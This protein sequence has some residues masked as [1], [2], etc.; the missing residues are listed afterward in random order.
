[1][2]RTAQ[3]TAQLTIKIYGLV[4]TLSQHV[5]R[6]RVEAIGRTHATMQVRHVFA[7]LRT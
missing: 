5:T 7:E 1:M 2:T 4:Q 3:I 6:T